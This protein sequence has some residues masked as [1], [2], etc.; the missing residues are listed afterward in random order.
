MERTVKFGFD[1]G[2][3]SV[4]VAPLWMAAAPLLPEGGLSNPTPT[5]YSPSHKPPDHQQDPVVG[6]IFGKWIST[7]SSRSPCWLAS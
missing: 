5:L 1:A 3:S 7:Q 6:E 4:L 2:Q